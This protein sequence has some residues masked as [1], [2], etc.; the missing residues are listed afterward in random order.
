MSDELWQVL[1]CCLLLVGIWKEGSI[2]S[3][4]ERKKEKKKEKRKKEVFDKSEVGVGVRG[5]N[6]LSFFFQWSTG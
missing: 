6:F 4:Y 3:T 5:N 2:W 1:T